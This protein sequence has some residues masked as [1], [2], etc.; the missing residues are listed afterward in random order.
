MQHNN[1]TGLVEGGHMGVLV[2]RATQCQDADKDFT[3]TTATNVENEQ[4][5]A[6]LSP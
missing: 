5:S 1:A 3:D 2:V 4:V 6:C